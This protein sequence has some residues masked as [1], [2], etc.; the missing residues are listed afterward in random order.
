MLTSPRFIRLSVATMGCISSVV[1]VALY[2]RVATPIAVAREH[3]EF[4]QL[5]QLT[6]W[7]AKYCWFGLLVPAALFT[8]GVFSVVGSKRRSAFELIVGC[9]WLFAFLWFAI[10]LFIW[11]LPQISTD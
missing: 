11:L 9:Q 4:D 5:P 10:C 8:A 6:Q 7:L 1:F 3:L 2:S